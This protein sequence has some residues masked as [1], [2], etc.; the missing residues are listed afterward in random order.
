MAWS[1]DTSSETAKPVHE[2]TGI[3]KVQ[4]ALPPAPSR[5]SLVASAESFLGP[6]FRSWAQTPGW[7]AFRL[8]NEQFLPV[9][10]LEHGA[11]PVATCSHAPAVPSTQEAIEATRSGLAA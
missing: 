3:W 8:M 2:E 5:L 4:V 9:L 6:H 7:P 1:S 11:R 10:A